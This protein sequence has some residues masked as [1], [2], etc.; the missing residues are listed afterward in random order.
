MF[1]SGVA[2]ETK[3]SA[4][5]GYETATAAD[6]AAESGQANIT[7]RIGVAPHRQMRAFHGA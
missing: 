3:E 5:A 6:G 7:A 2:D 4:T 1:V